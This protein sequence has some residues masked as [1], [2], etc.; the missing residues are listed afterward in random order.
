MKSSTVKVF[1]VEHSSEIRKGPYC[2]SSILSSETRRRLDVHSSNPDFP[3]AYQDGDLRQFYDHRGMA[4]GFAS[5]RQLHNWFDDHLL[6]HLL[7]DGFQ[8]VAY[9]LPATKVYYGEK[10]VL[11]HYRFARQRQILL[12]EKIT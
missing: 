10:Q 1:R 4:H 2:C 3:T 12:E 7:D 6:K 11:Y 9:T 5:L 8:V